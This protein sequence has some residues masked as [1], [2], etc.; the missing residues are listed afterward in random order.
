MIS[1]FTRCGYYSDLSDG[2]HTVYR[3]YVTGQ[4]AIYSLQAAF[5]PYGYGRYESSYVNK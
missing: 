5:C 3:Q 2:L 4:N 1:R